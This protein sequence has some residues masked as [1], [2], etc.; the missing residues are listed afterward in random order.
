VPRNGINDWVL[1]LVAALVFIGVAPLNAAAQAPCRASG[2]TLYVP[3][4]ST[5]YIDQRGADLSLT[6]TLFLRNTDTKKS[7]TVIEAAHYDQSGGLVKEYVDQP[8]VIP[9]LG[10]RR[11]LLA[12]V[13][14][15]KSEGAAVIVRWS[16]PE[17]MA[18]PVVESVTIG[19]EGTQGISFIA[20]AR[21]LKQ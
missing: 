10:S 5:V 12:G 2:Q 6:S 11:F 21:V 18:C 4:Y 20:P 7:L 14:R 1:L 16:A 13:G 9:P 8:V 19:A 15:N 17:S 3:V